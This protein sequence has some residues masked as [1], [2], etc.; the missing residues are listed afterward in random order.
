MPAPR[1]REEGRLLAKLFAFI[2][3]GAGGEQR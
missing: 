3:V 2:H 1:R